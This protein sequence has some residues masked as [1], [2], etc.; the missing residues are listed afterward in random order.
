M[1]GIQ[2]FSP[3]DHGYFIFCIYRKDNYRA[4][5][6]VLSN[7]TWIDYYGADNFVRWV[8]L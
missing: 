8:L 7:K 4:Y 2:R 3:D 1:F 5:M 6:M